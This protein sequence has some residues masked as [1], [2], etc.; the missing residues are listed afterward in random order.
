MRIHDFDK[1]ENA[2]SRNNHCGFFYIHFL[3]GGQQ[4]WQLVMLNIFIFAEP[5]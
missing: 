3:T 4:F 5:Q 2:L 1:K